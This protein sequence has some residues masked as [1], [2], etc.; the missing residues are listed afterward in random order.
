VKVTLDK[1][2]HI[3]QVESRMGG[4]TTV[5]TYSEYGDWNG[6]DYLSDVMFPKAYRPEAREHDHRRSDDHQD[7]HL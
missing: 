6:A 1:D 3:E 5:T 7:E 2:N 4:V